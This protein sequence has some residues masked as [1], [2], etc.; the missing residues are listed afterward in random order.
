MN[1]SRPNTIPRFSNAPSPIT[2]KVTGIE[3]R[4][5][6]TMPL[7]KEIPPPAYFYTESIEWEDDLIFV[8]CGILK[9]KTKEKNVWQNKRVSTFEKNGL[10]DVSSRTYPYRFDA[11][12]QQREEFGLSRNSNGG[13]ACDGYHCCREGFVLPKNEKKTASFDACF[14]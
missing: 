12:K 8:T 9:V 6:H 1:S 2:I 3:E 7:R 4:K 14:S 11:I 13:K 5:E 10:W